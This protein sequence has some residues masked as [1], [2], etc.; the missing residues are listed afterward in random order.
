[1]GKLVV[2]RDCKHRM[3]PKVY[4]RGVTPSHKVM[5]NKISLFYNSLSSQYKFLS[6]TIMMTKI[7]GPREGLYYNNNEE[8][9]PTLGMMH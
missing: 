4:S 7:T 8:P 1:M 3:T 5:L 9:G 6:L 2:Q